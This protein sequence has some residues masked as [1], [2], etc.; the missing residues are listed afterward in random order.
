LLDLGDL[1]VPDPE[2]PCSERRHAAL[3]RAVVLDHRRDERDLPRLDVRDDQPVAAPL[4]H[5]PPEA[6][7][8]LEALAV[9]GEAHVARERQPR[10]IVRGDRVEIT[11]DEA[12]ETRPVAGA[13]LGAGALGGGR[14]GGKLRGE[15]EARGE[16][17]PCSHRFLL[18]LGSRPRRAARAAYGIDR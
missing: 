9:L 5:A 17:G 12:L 8:D 13:R 6:V 2:P 7:A 3:G 4:F 10:R 15:R 1:A 11:L 18:V 14:G 16:Y